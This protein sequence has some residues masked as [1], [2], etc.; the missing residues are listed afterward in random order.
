MLAQKDASLSEPVSSVELDREAAAG[1]RGYDYRADEWVL[2]DRDTVLRNPKKDFS[3]A[4]A[5][6]DEIWKEDS[7]MES[8][9]KSKGAAGQRPAEAPAAKGAPIIIVPESLASVVTIFNAKEFLEQGY[10]VSSNEQRA[11]LKGTPDVVRIQR[12]YVSRFGHALPFLSL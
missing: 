5:I 10:W 7:R 3:M 2:S 6:V 8:R 12:K 9:P 11:K 1:P 4:I